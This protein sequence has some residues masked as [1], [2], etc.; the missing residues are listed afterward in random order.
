MYS[1]FNKLKGYEETSKQYFFFKVLRQLRT[2]TESIVKEK[3]ANSIIDE[4][5]VPK[6][7]VFYF[8][9][10]IYSHVHTL[11]GSFLPLPLLHHPLPPSLPGRSC[12]DSTLTDLYIGS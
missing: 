1:L 9:L 11:F 7:N 10:F 2:G 3:N 4:Q 12:V 6:D 5:K 8:F